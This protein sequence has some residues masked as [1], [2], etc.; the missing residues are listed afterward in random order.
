MALKSIK[1]GRGHLFVSVKSKL[2]TVAPTKQETTKGKKEKVTT[3][4]AKTS[5]QKEP[6]GG[7]AH[8]GTDQ[9]PILSKF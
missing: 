5:R 6:K 3:K 8:T 9:A 2:S 1:E 7:T 4:Q